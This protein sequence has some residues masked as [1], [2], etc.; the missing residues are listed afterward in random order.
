M[1]SIAS[2]LGMKLGDVVAL[3]LVMQLESIGAPCAMGGAARRGPVLTR[4]LVRIDAQG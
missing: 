1:K 3:N 4:P 2:A